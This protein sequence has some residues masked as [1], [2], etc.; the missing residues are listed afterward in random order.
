[1]EKIK[2]VIVALLI[3]AILFSGITLLMHF[4]AFDP[5]SFQVRRVNY[6]TEKYSDPTDPGTLNLV[7]TKPEENE[8]G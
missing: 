8:Q 4:F 2:T 7:V 6:V 5:D 3:V 1:M